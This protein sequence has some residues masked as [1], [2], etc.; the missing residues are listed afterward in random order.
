MCSDL[1]LQL[2]H[3]LLKSFLLVKHNFIMGVVFCPHLLPRQN[4]HSLGIV[5]FSPVTDYQSQI[6]M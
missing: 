5:G 6:W 3:Q 4:H 1:I 2:C